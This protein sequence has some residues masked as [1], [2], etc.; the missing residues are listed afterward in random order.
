MS[1]RICVMTGTRAEYGL[2][3][4]L[5]K[6]FLNDEEI[7]LKLVVTGMHLS[8]EFGLTYKLIEE[9]G[10]KID[11]KI[12]ILLSS[13]SGV[14]V[15]KAM[16]LA[17]LSFSEY[18][19]RSMPDMIVL[20]GDR[21]ETMAMATA[22]TV[23]NIPIAHLHGGEITEGAYDEA[24]RHSI[25]KM[26]YLHFTSNS[27]HKKRVIQL[28]E[29][30]NRV[31]NVGAIG[32]ERILNMDYCSETEIKERLGIDDENKYVIVA[33]HPVTLEK[34]TSEE[35]FNELIMALDQF[36]NLDIIFIKANSDNDGR[37]INILID[38]Y[39]KDNINRVK[40]FSTLNSKEYLSALKYCECIIGNSSSGIIEAP[41]FKICSVNIGDRQRGR[42]QAKSIV[43]C[44]PNSLE[45]ERAII[46]AIELKDSGFIESVKNPYGDGE[47]SCKIIKHIKNTINEGI[48]LKKKFYDVNY[49]V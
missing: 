7:E 5:I 16:A 15:S 13:D 29:Q 37:I 8:P 47:T 26:S 33:F 3:N 32:V 2:L 4:P 36:K 25:T 27:E 34:S 45:I 14:G 48:D 35:Q 30:P 19:N 10:I 49:Y 41:S 31:F 21:F 39:E 43:N 6:K 17:M 24:F 42:L 18:L 1:K 22:A 23:L 12:E 44:E 28:G 46:K 9:E 11:E 20:L 38:K 40:S